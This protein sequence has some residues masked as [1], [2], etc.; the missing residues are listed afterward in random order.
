VAGRQR[1]GAEPPGH[2]EHRVEAHVAVAAHAGVRRQALGVI[3]QPRLHD[4]R[5]ELVAQVQREVRQAHPVGHRPRRA[6][7]AGRAAGL[8]AVVLGVAPELEGHARD[9]GAGAGEQQRGDRRVHPARRGDEDPLAAAGRRD[10]GVVRGGLAE[11]AVQRVGGELGGVQLA[12][13]QPAERGGDGVRPHAGGVEQRGPGDE[14]DR[15]AAGRD[16]RTAAAGLEARVGDDA[17]LDADR[18][19]HEVATGS[20][21]RGAVTGP[22]GRVTTPA[23][24]QQMLLEALVRHAPKATTARDRRT[25]AT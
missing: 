5:A 22:R 1:A 3:G 20:P 13:A 10:R 6:H 21:A 19:A 18:D 12:R 24:M 4:A 14:L 16:R 2:V 7:R 8:L 11:R 9:L 23:G 17:V 15:G 25:A